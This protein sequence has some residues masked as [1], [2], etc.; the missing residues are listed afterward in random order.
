MLIPALELDLEL[1]TPAAERLADAL[2]ALDLSEGV[3]GRARRWSC[4]AP[5]PTAGPARAA[6]AALA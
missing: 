5:E 2:A 6:A 1:R 3:G 4:R